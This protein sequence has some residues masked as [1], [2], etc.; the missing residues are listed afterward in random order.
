MAKCVHPNIVVKSKKT[1]LLYLSG[2]DS[3]NM[4]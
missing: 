4:K 1:A 3:A 2:M